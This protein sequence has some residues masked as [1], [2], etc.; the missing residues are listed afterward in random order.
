MTKAEKREKKRNKLKY[1]MQESG[2]SVK[3]LSRLS[4]ERAEKLRE[5]NKVSPVE[6]KKKRK[7]TGSTQ[8]WPCFILCRP[9]NI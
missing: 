3:Y 2:R 4:A 6:V 8:S 9:I 5:R 1:G 7:K